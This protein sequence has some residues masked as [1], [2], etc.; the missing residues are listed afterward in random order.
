[1]V[2][3]EQPLQRGGSGGG[4][5]A[6]ARTLSVLL[7]PCRARGGDHPLF[8]HYALYELR[9]YLAGLEELRATA[10]IDV[11]PWTPQVSE[12]GESE[13]SVSDLF[14]RVVGRSPDVVAF[15]LYSWTIE[16]CHRLARF[17]K[18]M[19]PGLVTVVGGPEVADRA[20]FA[21]EFPAFDVIV[22]GEG[23]IPS[24]AII[25]RL[26][27]GNVDLS[28]IPNVSA[29]TA[30]GSFT[31]G[32]SR[33]EVEDPAAVPNFLTEPPFGGPRDGTVAY[34]GGA[35]GC[36]RHC[37]YCLWGHQQ[38]VQKPAA[39]V[40]GELRAIAARPDVETICF[41]DYDL[42]NVLRQDPDTFHEIARALSEGR[43]PRI[44]FSVSPLT[45]TD[46]MFLDVLRVVRVDHIYLGLQ[47]L[48]AA[49]LRAVSR[50]WATEQLAALPQ[51]P[52]G[53]RRLI[54][55]QL[56]VPLPEETPASFYEGIERLI[57][58]GFYR[59]QVFPLMILRGSALHRKAAGLGLKRFTGAPYFCFETPTFPH[60]EWVEACAVG[61]VLWTVDHAAP[62]TADD[63]LARWERLGDLFRRRRGLVRE[64][65]E[66]VRAGQPVARIA[67]EL[68]ADAGLGPAGPVEAGGPAAAPPPRRPR[69]ALPPAPLIEEL[70]RRH[71]LRML[72]ESWDGARLTV[73]AAERGR[74]TLIEIEIR[75]ADDPGPCYGAGAKLKVAYKGPLTDLK[76]L[77]ELIGW[78]G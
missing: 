44:T 50:G 51:V 66:L 40:V 15:S 60:R 53:L 71:G 6:A 14:H 59:V 76:A 58:L 17:L 27:T 36:N 21:A 8:E 63:G 75:P 39:Q 52:E 3:E 35:R 34:F 68:I 22:E 25:G 9:A 20:R 29:R 47:S 62:T 57:G 19:L 72:D 11:L 73:R 70:L 43:N 41:N 30:D 4:P 55:A 61:N 7:M 49:A 42:F 1:V 12:T 28:G 31:H 38:F 32:P 5:P 23:E 65:R 77:D 45:L 13:W 69:E 56:L 46:P 74:P 64:I 24:R 2:P 78:G 48:S 18:E 67:S 37:A 33:P 10:T 26:A 54:R 16:P